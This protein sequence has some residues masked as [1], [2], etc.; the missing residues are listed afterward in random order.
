MNN[1]VAFWYMVSEYGRGFGE[2]MRYLDLNFAI[3]DRELQRNNG[4]GV[5]A[6]MV[7]TARI[8]RHLF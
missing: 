7:G 5:C 1:K 8:C 2:V 3:C 6:W 4:N